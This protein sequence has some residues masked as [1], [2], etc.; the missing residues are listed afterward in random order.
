MPRFSVVIAPL[1]IWG[2]GAGV[3]A[4]L[5][6]TEDLLNP[7]Q[8]LPI[9]SRI[10]CD[11]STNFQ[12]DV[13]FVSAFSPGGWQRSFHLDEF[14]SKYCRHADLYF[15]CVVHGRDRWKHEWSSESGGPPGVARHWLK[16]CFA[17]ES[18]DPPKYI[19]SGWYREGAGEKLPWRQAAIKQVSAA[20]EIYEFTDS[21]GGTARVE[22][23][24]K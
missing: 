11:G 8:G 15:I 24:R 7:V 14:E 4:G 13:E 20:P 23:K 19:L 2:L 21:N 5:H 1:L 18:Q 16:S 10:P 3:C 12:E 22:I 17:H 6:K 9:A